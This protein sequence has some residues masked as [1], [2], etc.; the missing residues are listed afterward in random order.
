MPPQARVPQERAILEKQETLVPSI[1]AS[2]PLPLAP[3]RA[4]SPEAGG[5][6]SAR[7]NQIHPA[8]C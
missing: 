6:V 7:A 3:P 2:F 5:T 4:A 8:V 1:S